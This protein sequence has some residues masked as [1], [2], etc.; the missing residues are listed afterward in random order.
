M[1]KTLFIL[2]FLLMLF[3]AACNRTS[4]EDIVID[5]SIQTI[6]S[7]QA[8]G[9]H[10][11]ESL[12]ELSDF[13]VDNN[14]DELDIADYDESFFE[15]ASLV[16]IVFDQESTVVYVDGMKYAKNRLSITLIRT[17]EP[18]ENTTSF[19]VIELARKQLFKP[20]QVS[21]EIRDAVMTNGLVPFTYERYNSQD[22]FSFE[23]WEQMMLFES[24]AHII[25]STNSFARFSTEFPNIVPADTSSYSSCFFE[26]Y[27]L[28]IIQFWAGD[29]YSSNVIIDSVIIEGY[30]VTVDI[31]FTVPLGTRVNTIYSFWVTIDKNENITLLTY[32][33][34]WWSGFSN[35]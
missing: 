21:H 3:V 1:K 12:L 31:K 18:L 16:L 8:T 11:F 20:E 22:D 30:H 33:F 35:R 34:I 32:D 9:T 17:T 19:L 25:N 2:S 26:N 27:T 10:V 23:D 29:Y 14:L 24:N 13:K 6:N 15:D 4:V 28:L 5:H 7:T